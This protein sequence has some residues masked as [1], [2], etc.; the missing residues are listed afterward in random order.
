MFWYI[1]IVNAIQYLQII[2]INLLTQAFVYPC[3]VVYTKAY[4]GNTAFAYSRL[5]QADSAKPQLD[6]IINTSILL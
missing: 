5:Q 2:K 6:N 1:N 4:T 3:T